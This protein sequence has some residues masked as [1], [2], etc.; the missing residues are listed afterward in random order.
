MIENKKLKFALT[1][2]FE[3]DGEFTETE[4]KDGIMDGIQRSIPSLMMDSDE[5]TV[6]INET[7]IF[8]F[9]KS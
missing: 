2:L 1:I 6:F 8:L 7:E 3:V 5:R 4:L 9:E